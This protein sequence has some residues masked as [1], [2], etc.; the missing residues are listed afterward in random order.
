M[1]LINEI[2]VVQKRLDGSR[3]SGVVLNAEQIENM[4]YEAIGRGLT[5]R[6]NVL[7]AESGIVITTDF[8][9][10][11]LNTS[12][13]RLTTGDFFIIT[14]KVQ[15]L[16]NIQNEYIGFFYHGKVRNLKKEKRRSKNIRAILS[17]ITMISMFA[18]GF[19]A[20][21]FIIIMAIIAVASFG[22]SS[23]MMGLS[24]WQ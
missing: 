7:H 20:S 10:A 24:K 13:S 8:F 14:P 4:K 6:T 22:Y 16:Y 19:N 21:F 17:A 18:I 23:L 9:E 11:L 2:D 5:I 1:D 15:P 12:I 3:E